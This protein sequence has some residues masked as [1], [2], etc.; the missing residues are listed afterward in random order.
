VSSSIT[1]AKRYELDVIHDATD[2]DR[3]IDIQVDKMLMDNLL[4]NYHLK[5]SR[6]RKN[7]IKEGILPTADIESYDFLKNKDS[8]NE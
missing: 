2:S 7:R 8:S 3:K 4:K 1:S 5:F 6:A